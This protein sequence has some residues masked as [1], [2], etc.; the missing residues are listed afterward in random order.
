MDTMYLSGLI[1]TIV[2]V[3]RDEIVITMQRDRETDG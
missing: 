2:I 3:H 1:E